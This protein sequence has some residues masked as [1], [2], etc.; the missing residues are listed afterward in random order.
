MT[1]NPKLYEHAW[2]HPLVYSRRRIGRPDVLHRRS[3]ILLHDYRHTARLAIM[4]TGRARVLSVRQGNHGKRGRR[5][6][7]HRIYRLMDN[8]R[9]V[10]NRNYASR[11][12]RTLRHNRHRHS[13]CQGALETD[14]NERHAILPDGKINLRQ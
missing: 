3:R 12:R 10:G 8:R 2:K 7:R 11:A 4:E 9:M 6:F 13:V 5:L 14:E 1:S